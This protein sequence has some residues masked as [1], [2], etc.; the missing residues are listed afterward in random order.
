MSP[1]RTVLAD[2]TSLLLASEL[3]LLSE[4]ATRFDQICIPWSTMELLLIESQSCRFHQPSR[5]APTPKELREL[6]FNN[7]L[8]PHVL[9]GGARSPSL[10][11]SGANWPNYFCCATFKRPSCQTPACTPSPVLYGSD[12]RARR[13]RRDLS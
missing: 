10:R 1:V 2:F 11:K 5:V 6:V 13:I 3:E 9:Y 8:R 4:L 7:I 12:R